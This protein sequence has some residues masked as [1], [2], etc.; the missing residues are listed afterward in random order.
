RAHGTCLEDVNGARYIDGNSSWWT[1]SLGHGH[2]RLL[3]A[4]REQAE[5]LAHCSLAGTTHEP[6][7]RLAE[8]LVAVAP[9]GLTRVF[10]T[11][12]G[13]TAIEVAVKIA[14]QYWR[15][16]GRPAKTRFVALDGAYHGDSIGAMSLGG[17]DVFK[18][19]YAGV[20][21]ECFHAASPA[22]ASYAQAFAAM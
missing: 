19:P 12:N 16:S 14:V 15:Q 1:A 22:E 9:R 6:A 18:R 10:Y 11:D 17:V 5:R 3:R 7:A 4:M 13:S 8:E 2:P 21:F 20:L